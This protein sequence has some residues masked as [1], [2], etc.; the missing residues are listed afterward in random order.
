M[1]GNSTSSAFSGR[2]AISFVGIP[3]S[4]LLVI[5]PH[6]GWGVNLNLGQIR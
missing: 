1:L 6:Q 4:G 3:L 2:T 5:G